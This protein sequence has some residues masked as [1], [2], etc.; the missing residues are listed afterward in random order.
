MSEMQRTGQSVTIE[1]TRELAFEAM[2][3]DSELREWFCDQAWT[4]VRPGGRYALHWNQGYHVEGRFLE[5]DVPRRA[6]IAWRGTGEPG[7]TTVEVTVGEAGGGV[8]VTVVHGGFGPGAEWNGPL[9][10][11]RKGWDVGLENLKSTLETGIDLRAARQPFLGISLDLLTPERAEQEGI[12]ADFGIYVTGTVPGSGA[13]AAGLCSGDVVV[14]LGDMQ[15]AGFQAL[16]TALRAHQAGDEVALEVVRRQEHLTIPVTLGRRPQPEIPAGVEELADRLD[17]RCREVDEELRIAV[18]GLT[19][20]EAEECP[21]EGQWSVKQ[22]LAH[23]SDGE[24]VGHVFLTNMAVNGWLDAAPV[25]NEQIAG[26][27]EAILAVTPT[28]S[29]LVERFIGDETETIEI[30]RRLP[31]QAWAHK[32]R[33]RRIAQL[34]LLGPDHTREH[35]QQIVRAVAIVRG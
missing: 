28:L 32:A 35:V 30:L 25:S 27:L 23:L 12:A 21:E 4:D 11:A 14:A 22:I 34:A 8:E 6:V 26:R 15:T 31:E 16:S 20:E 7:D 3:R 9:G 17:E 10:E 2:T 5:L 13:E 1:S 24:R 33:F 19:E 18:A 29:G